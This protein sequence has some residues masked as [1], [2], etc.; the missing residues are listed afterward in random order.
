MS[1]SHAART[2]AALGMSGLLGAV[3]IVQPVQAAE[4]GLP[5]LEL[6]EYLGSWEESDEDWLLFND[7]TEVDDEDTE[8][9]D[10][11]SDSSAEAMADEDMTELQP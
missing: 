5:D 8:P 7:E 3:S 2:V 11:P 9:R 6:L 1:G 10:A 4:D